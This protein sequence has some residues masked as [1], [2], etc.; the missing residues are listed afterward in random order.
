MWKLILTG[1][2]LRFNLEPL[3]KYI[4]INFVY[5]SPYAVTVA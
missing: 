4:E 5:E 3:L 1:N 2:P